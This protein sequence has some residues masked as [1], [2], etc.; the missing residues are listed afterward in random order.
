MKTKRKLLDVKRQINYKKVGKPKVQ[1]TLVKK[2][3]KRKTTKKAKKR[4]DAILSRI[5]D[6][7]VIGAEVGVL[8]GNTAH[9]IL[10]ARPLLVH[11]MIDPW[12]P[13]AKSSDY[14]KTGDHDSHQTKEEFDECYEKTKQLCSFAGERAIYHRMKS[15][16]AVKKFED[17]S[18]DFVFVDGDHSYNGVKKDIE[19]WLPKVKPSG[20]IGGHDY[21]HPRLP[22]VKKAVDEMFPG[23]V[24]LDVNRTWFVK[25]SDIMDK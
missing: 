13:P 6:E 11:N 10:K 20:W 9:R 18:L 21:D 3:I 12:R 25:I 1:K 15:E 22:G 4:W 16:T 24:E 17:A 2:P 19:M 8:N 14:Y 5:P 23:G 7:F